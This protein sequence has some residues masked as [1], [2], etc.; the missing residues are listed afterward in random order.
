MIASFIMGRQRLELGFHMDPIALFKRSARGGG[1]IV[2]LPEGDDE[3]ILCAARR[4]ADENLA[5]PCL[6]G[7]RNDIEQNAARLGLSLDKIAVIDTRTSSALESYA[8]A[9]LQARPR[10]N[11][12]VAARLIK[13]PLFYASMMIR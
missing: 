4:I 3:R 13:K 2:A 11:P 7:A 1:K 10:S 8:R 6:L 12:R 9:Y 5:R